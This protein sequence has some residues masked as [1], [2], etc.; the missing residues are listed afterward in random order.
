MVPEAPPICSIVFD[1]D[2]TLYVSP[3]V[4]REIEEAADA[5]VAGTRG[6]SL[7]AGR[8]LLKRARD[9]LAEEGDEET[10]LTRTCMELGI[11]I[12]E[13]H[14]AFQEHVRPERHLLPDPVLGA[15]LH[16][17]Q[18]QCSLYIY[19]NNNLPLA[20]R[21]LSLLGVEGLFE[22]LYT[23]EFTGQPKPDFEA[24]RKVVED[25]GGPPES[26]LFVGDRQ[27]VDLGPAEQEGMATLLVRETADLLQIHRL[28][29]MIP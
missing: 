9:R 2:G 27:G 8:S 17:L 7:E 22:R 20:S 4:A 29:G 23:I 3:P 11:D 16:S 5:L 24:F 10:T 13:L 14:R 26:F 6:L 1:L 15:L 25:I 18:D 21:I 12:F 19:T 28:L